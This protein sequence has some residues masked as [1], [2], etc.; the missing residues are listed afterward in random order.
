[1]KLKGTHVQYIHARVHTYLH[2]RRERRY[3]MH[4]YSKWRNCDEKNG[5]KPRANEARDT[6][7]YGDAIEKYNTG[8]RTGSQ[9]HRSKERTKDRSRATLTRV[10]L[11]VPRPSSKSIF[12]IREMKKNVRGHRRTAVARRIARVEDEREREVKGNGRRQGKRKRARKERKKEKNE[13]A[14]REQISPSWSPRFRPVPRHRGKR[15]LREARDNDDAPTT[16]GSREDD[17]FSP[18]RLRFHE[19]TFPWAYARVARIGL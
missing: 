1:M 5:K 11:I 8:T 2:I 14:D 7:A 18:L 9:A 4:Y 19:R 12:K 13:L 3:Y 15:S 16:D 10:T 17:S 6:R